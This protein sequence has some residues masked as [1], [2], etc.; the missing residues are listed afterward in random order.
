MGDSQQT[1]VAVFLD[2]RKALYV[3]NH[4]TLVSKLEM[5]D[6]TGSVYRW[7]NNQ[8]ESNLWWHIRVYS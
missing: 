1:S 4:K 8:L 5:G 6:K 3:I 7:F 2:L